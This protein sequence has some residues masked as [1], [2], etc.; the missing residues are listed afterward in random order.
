VSNVEVRGSE[1]Y[2]STTFR[3]MII[4]APFLV[5]LG[6][7]MMVFAFRGAQGEAF[8]VAGL[9]GPLTLGA[10]LYFAFLR[11]GLVLDAEKKRVTAWW[12][13]L[14]FRGEHVVDAAGRSF[15][16]EHYTTHSKES[17]TTHFYRILLGEETL[18]DISEHQG[19]SE[20]AND[21]AKRMAKHVGAR[22]DGQRDCPKMLKRDAFRAKYALAPLIAVTVVM[23]VVGVVFL[24]TAR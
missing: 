10:G 14:V 1:M 20:A 2:V 16:V 22:F 5:V 3:F 19:G 12:K 4:A 23:F 13:W 24:I 11:K 15:A 6:L 17:G 7:A 18:H 21:L 8:W 9:L